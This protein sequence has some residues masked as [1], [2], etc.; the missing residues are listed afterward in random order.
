M[1]QIVCVLFSCV[2][3]CSFAAC[4]KS[5][6]TGTLQTEESNEATDNQT[7]KPTATTP[8]AT[9]NE[10]V[11]KMKVSVNGH[12]FTATLA[13]NSSARALAD[14]LREKPLVIEMHDYGNFEKVGPIG[15]NLPQN[16]EQITTQPGDIILYQGNSITIYYDTNSWNFT[17]IGK[18]DTVEQAELQ[19]VLGSGA[20]TVTFSID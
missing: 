16:N 14:L 15:T 9:E 5:E 8:P 17:R 20:V 4:G 3:L 12:I 7:E 1:K 6:E 18:L 13:D 19:S 2:M 10:T 11:G